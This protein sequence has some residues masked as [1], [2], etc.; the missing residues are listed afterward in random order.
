MLSVGYLE[1]QPS[2]VQ[3]RISSCQRATNSIIPRAEQLSPSCC[4][5]QS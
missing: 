1:L 3:I 4:A 5:F 2:E